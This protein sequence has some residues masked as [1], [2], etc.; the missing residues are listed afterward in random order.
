MI[1]QSRNSLRSHHNRYWYWYRALRLYVLVFL[2]FPRVPEKLNRR[3]RNEQ[4]MIGV[5]SLER[6]KKVKRVLYSYIN[7]YGTTFLA[8][9][10]AWSVVLPYYC[11]IVLSLCHVAVRIR[12]IIHS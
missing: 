5:I 6:R 1:A 4:P 7:Q 9:V 12:S 3:C 11:T 8:E 10:Q 2:Q